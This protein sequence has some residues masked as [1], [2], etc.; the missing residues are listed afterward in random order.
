M[1]YAGVDS[2]YFT[3][4]IGKE[5]EVSIRVEFLRWSALDSDVSK[6]ANGESELICDVR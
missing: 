1:C 6:M 2:N 5:W 3:I 4:K